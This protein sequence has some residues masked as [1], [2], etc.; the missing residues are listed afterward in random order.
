MTRLLDAI[1]RH[2]GWRIWRTP[3]ETSIGRRL[4][5]YEVTR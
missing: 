1:S 2:Y 4:H 3:T 5:P